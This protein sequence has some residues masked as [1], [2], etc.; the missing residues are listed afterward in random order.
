MIDSIDWQ[1]CDDGPG[2]DPV[3]TQMVQISLDY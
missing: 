2:E 1:A 3:A